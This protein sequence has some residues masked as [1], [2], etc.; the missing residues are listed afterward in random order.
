MARR[1]FISYLNDDDGKVDTYCEL[2]EQTISYVQIKM[3]QNIITLPYS[4][5]LKMKEVSA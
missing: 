1:I 5:I 3:G 2:L 4:R